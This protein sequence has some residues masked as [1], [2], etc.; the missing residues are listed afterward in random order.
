M[1]NSKFAA[2]IMTI[3]I[4][5]RVTEAALDTV[6]R[7]SLIKKKSDHREKAKDYIPMAS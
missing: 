7:R 6:I 5:I 2:D 3:L 1:E 4:R